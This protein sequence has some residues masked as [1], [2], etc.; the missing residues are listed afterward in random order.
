[1]ARTPVQNNTDYHGPTT[2]RN[3]T[4]V[5]TSEQVC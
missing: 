4:A 2:T 1:M 5:A 3:L